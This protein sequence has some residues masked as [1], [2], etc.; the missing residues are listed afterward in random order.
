MEQLNIA[1]SVTLDVTDENEGDI[2]KRFTE[3]YELD[4]VLRDFLSAGK[5]NYSCECRIKITGR[6]AELKHLIW[7]YGVWN[8]GVWHNGVWYDGE[9]KDGEW[10]NGIW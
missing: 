4:D 5:K 8:G 10:K 9:W 7:R 3:E 1:T 6:Y 2:I